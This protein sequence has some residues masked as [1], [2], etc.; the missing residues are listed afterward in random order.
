MHFATG[1]STHENINEKKNSALIL[2]C[3]ARKK[4]F[5][6]LKSVLYPAI[7]LKMTI[8][9]EDLS[10]P[11]Q[12]SEE[13]TITSSGL[14][15]D[16]GIGLNH[17]LTKDVLVIVAASCGI[18]TGKHTSS[19]T[20]KDKTDTSEG[21]YT[22]ITL[23]KL[24]LGLEAYLAKWFTIRAGINKSYYYDSVKQEDFSKD[25]E[26][27]RSHLD[28]YFAYHF[29]VGLQF[30]KFTIDWEIRDDLLWNAPYIVTGK[31]SNFASSLSLKFCLK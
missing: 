28:S 1:I 19:E 10:Y 5:E 23:P 14:S 22:R 12:P 4:M 18:L 27:K 30:S 2:R 25:D 16:P 26:L 9:E 8:Y 6:T 31:E 15:I 7:T 29:G 3:A 17:W 24:E 13:E 20:V 11:V 21:S